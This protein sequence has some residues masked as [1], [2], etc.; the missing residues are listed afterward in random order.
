[1][2]CMDNEKSP[3]SVGKEGGK[4]DKEEGQRSGEKQRYGHC[5][6]CEKIRILKKWRISAVMKPHTT[7]RNM[8]VHP[9]DKLDP[10]EGVYKIACRNCGKCYIGE[11][12]RKLDVRVKEHREEVE[13]LD[14]GRSFTRDS[15]KQAQ[16]ERSKSAIVDH[17]T[18]ANHVID[19]DSAKLVQ[20]EGDWL[21]RG[22][23]EA[24][25]IRRNPRNMNRD[26]GRYQLSHL[27]DDLLVPGARD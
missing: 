3:E 27:Y 1:M 8:L 25:N 23:K 12:K 26:E 24:I 2:S 20:R 9:K 5:T 17:V 16:R 22:I 15:K 7:L 19:W 4:K 14:K 18:Q 21:V 13:K 6:I 10:R 11:T